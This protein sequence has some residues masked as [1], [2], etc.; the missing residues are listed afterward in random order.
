MESRTPA[1]RVQDYMRQ[2][3]G[4]ETFHRG[5]M[6]FTFT[7]GVKYVADECGAHWLI[8]LIESWQTRPE[9][10]AETFQLW[11][12]ENTGGD[13]DGWVITCRTDS[14]P[15]GR[16]LCRQEL[17]VSDFPV[18]LSPFTIYLEHGT[19]LLPNER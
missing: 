8:D 17:A 15:D 16:E 3:N 19:I 14:A 1:E 11:S 4:S 13:T 5:T 10:K 7:D 2:T 6:G 18:A 12:L 9:V